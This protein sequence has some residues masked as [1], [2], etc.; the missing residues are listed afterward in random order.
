MPI[1]KALHW[2]PIQQRFVFK[3]A[4]LEYKFLHLNWPKCFSPYL[5]AH[6]SQ[7]EGV[8]LDLPQ[9][10]PSVYEMRLDLPYLSIIL[11]RGWN[12]SSSPKPTHLSTPLDRTFA[13]MQTVALIAISWLM[14]LD[15]APAIKRY[16]SLIVYLDM[17]KL[18]NWHVIIASEVFLHATVE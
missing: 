2:L 11:E 13:A 10:V 9:F 8:M 3:R 4:I 14:L 17:M 15:V 5:N 12:L 7:W 1:R 18:E 6:I 16:K